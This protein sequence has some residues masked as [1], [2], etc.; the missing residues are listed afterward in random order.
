[1]VIHFS[2][3]FRLTRSLRRRRMS[4]YIS[5]FTLAIPGI[6]ITANSCKLYQ[7]NPRTYLSCHNCFAF[8]SSGIWRFFGW[9]VRD[10]SKV[11]AHL[12]GRAAQIF[13][14]C[15]VLCLTEYKTCLFTVNGA[16]VVRCCEYV[17]LDGVARDA[18]FA[19]RD[20]RRLRRIS[21]SIAGNASE[22]RTEPLPNRDYN[23][24]TE[25]TIAAIPVNAVVTMH[26]SRPTFSCQNR[27]VHPL[28]LRLHVT[29]S[30]YYL[31]TS[32]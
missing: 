25:S 27:R 11:V 17:H 5:L 14:K 2:G 22:I 28:S 12:Q 3:R 19:Y 26:V 15:C 9:P 29:W 32:F 20:W 24:T 6:I 10:I 18:E 21:D 1:M 4:K 13:G 8:K 30:L 23:V 16:S 31:V 7:R